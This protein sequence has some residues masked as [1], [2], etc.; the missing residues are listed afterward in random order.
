MTQSKSEKV[1]EREHLEAT[2]GRPAMLVV[3]SWILYSLISIN[4][5]QKFTMNLAADAEDATISRDAK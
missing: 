1:G 3:V 5:G 2:R 4:L